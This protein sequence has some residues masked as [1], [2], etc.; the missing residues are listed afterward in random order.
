[1]ARVDDLADEVEAIRAGEREMN[2]KIFDLYAL[3]DD[4]RLLVEKERVRRT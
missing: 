3:S 2:A 1:M 4:E